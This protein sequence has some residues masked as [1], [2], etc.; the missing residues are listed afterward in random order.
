MGLRFYHQLEFKLLLLLLLHTTNT[1]I[2]LKKEDGNNNKSSSSEEVEKNLYIYN[3]LQSLLPEI[4]NPQFL[5]NLSLFEFLDEYFPNRKDENGDLRPQVLIFNQLEELFSFYPDN[6][7]EQQKQFFEQV[8]DSLENNPLLR[9]VFIIREDYL[10]QLDPIKSI[11]PEKLRPRFRLERLRRDEA[12][13][14]IKGPLTNIISNLGEEERKNIESEIKELIDD[15]LKIYV[16]TPYA[17]SSLRQVEGEFIEPI[18]LQVVCRRWWHEKQEASKSPGN[19]KKS[20]LEEELSN[21]NNALKDFYEEAIL[22]TSKQTGIPERD[23]RN[24]FQEKLITSSG[25]RSIIHRDHNSTGGINNKAVDILED[26]YYL[27][28]REW[29]SGASWYELTHDRLIKPITD[30]NTKW[31]Y[32]NER[33]KKNLILKVAIPSLTVPAIVVSVILFL[34][35]FSPHPIIPQPAKIIGDGPNASIC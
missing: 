10:A 24:W 33:K 6:W 18:Q 26:K 27:I 21:V 14:A 25:T 30:S 12:V 5:L 11:L 19:R 22:D 29:R 17:G 4:D 28:R 3:A 2:S 34:Y 35:V 7:I 20:N 9:I 13:L 8:A 1:Q 15:L 23:I 32:E 16:E 31:K